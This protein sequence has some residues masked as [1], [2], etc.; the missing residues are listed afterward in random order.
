[1]G[2]RKSRTTARPRKHG[3]FEAVAP[4][5]ELNAFVR[6]IT[7][8]DAA[9]TL[10]VGVPVPRQESDKDSRPSL[11]Y[12]CL[13]VVSAPVGCA[14][15]Y[16]ACADMVYKRHSET[17]AELHSFLV[18]QRLMSEMEMDTLASVLSEKDDLSEMAPFLK[19]P[20]RLRSEEFREAHKMK[21][22]VFDRSKVL[23]FF[24]EPEDDESDQSLLRRSRR[25]RRSRPASDE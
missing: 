18:T 22:D 21:L 2:L 5:E 25:R 11:R 9:R 14:F 10:I 6:H 4:G 17:D 8:L 19:T 16:N 12:A 13:G 3:F 24:D 23:S 15:N 7:L 20:G 1:M